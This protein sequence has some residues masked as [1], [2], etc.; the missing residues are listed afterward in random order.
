MQPPDKALLI[1][2]DAGVR[3]GSGHVMRCLALAQAWQEAG[4][5]ATI[6]THGLGPALRRRLAEQDLEIIDADFGNGG[7]DDARA[8]ISLAERLGADWVVVDGYHF[9]A[10]YQ[11]AIKDAGLR[12]LFIDD[13][14]HAKQYLADLVL[15]QNIHAK[16]SFYA[17]CHPDS[18]LLLGTRYALIRRE[19][20]PW[21]TWKRKIPVT[22]RRILVTLGGSDPDNI[23][24]TVLRALEQVGGLDMQV[25]VVVGGSNPHQAEIEAVAA[26]A[27][28]DTRLE[29]DATNMPEL[30]AWADLTV[31][32][33][34][35]TCW[36]ICLLGLPAVLLVLAENQRINCQVMGERGAAI[37]LG[38]AGGLDPSD[39]ASTLT[40]L[41]NNRD[42][43]SALSLQARTLVDGFGAERVRD[44]M[45]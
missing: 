1:R 24:P 36:E 33:G 20:W 30:M 44:A 5:R 35:S 2:A 6:L 37:N 40:G 4:Q 18:R 43:R 41:C 29:R 19:F 25:A 34:G 27:S 15:N 14:G 9:G 12:I 16:E 21:R 32:A 26:R 13:N 22:A 31:S 8:S 28:A 10:D 3:I 42:Q 11:R 23:T 17:D 45:K 7:C 39:L 38:P